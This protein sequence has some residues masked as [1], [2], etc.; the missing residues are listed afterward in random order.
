MKQVSGT[1]IRTA[2]IAAIGPHQQIT[3]AVSVDIAHT[4]KG[5]ACPITSSL[6]LDSGVSKRQVS[7]AGYRTLDDIDGTGSLTD[8][9]KGVGP[10]DKFGDAI[11][12]QITSPQSRASAI[13]GKLT[14]RDTIRLG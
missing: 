1:R 2:S 8:T 5:P 7:A 11:T 10:N 13:L 9:I 3:D 12:A 4:S 6:S 14:D